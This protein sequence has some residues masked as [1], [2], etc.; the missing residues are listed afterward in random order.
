[1]GYWVD[2]TTIDQNWLDGTYESI[3]VNIYVDI[4]LKE[5]YRVN[6]EWLPMQSQSLIYVSEKNG[7]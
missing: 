3:I 6:T 7:T 2:F 1:M 5:F 4:F